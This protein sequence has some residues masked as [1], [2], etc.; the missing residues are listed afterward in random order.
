MRDDLGR[1]KDDD[2]VSAVVHDE[3]AVRQEPMEDAAVDDR[4]DRVV[5]AEEEQGLLPEEG[6][7]GKRGVSKHEVKGTGCVSGVFA[8]SGVRRTHGR[9]GVI[10]RSCPLER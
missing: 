6:H 10:R 7:E 8:Q 5:G 2:Q 1:P 3:G 9:V 4:D